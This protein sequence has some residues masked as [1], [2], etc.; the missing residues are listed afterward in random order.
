MGGVG[1]DP[2]SLLWGGEVHTWASHLWLFGGIYAS[3]SSGVELIPCPAECR[4]D[5]LRGP[6]G[7]VVV[8]SG[9][10]LSVVGRVHGCFEVRLMAGEGL[11]ELDHPG[12]R[13]GPRMVV[14]DY[15]TFCKRCPKLV[16][17]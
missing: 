14:C 8:I 7:R 6:T 13:L 17:L 15:D 11:R 1:P 4:P 3:C 2:Y 5:F 10:G 9:E 12:A 16:G